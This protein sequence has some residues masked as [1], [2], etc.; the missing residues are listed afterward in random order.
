MPDAPSIHATCV[1]V[2]GVGVLIRGP[3]GAGKSDLALRL[4]DGGATLVADDRTVIAVLTGP[5]GIRAV[6]SPP[7]GLAGKLEVRGMGII[8]APF[9]SGVPL[10]L[11][12]DLAPTDEIERWPEVE[13]VEIAGVALPRLRLDAKT[14]SA[15]AKVRLAVRRLERHRLVS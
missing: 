13:T 8:D 9:V 3:S 2:D 6:A 11:V 5:D 4:I 7:P 1:A 15:D 12:C 10:V 14:S